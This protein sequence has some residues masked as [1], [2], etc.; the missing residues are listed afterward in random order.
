MDIKEPHK[1]KKKVSSGNRKPSDINRKDTKK[2][3]CTSKKDAKKTEVNQWKKKGDH[4]VQVLSS[5]GINSPLKHKQSAQETNRSGSSRRLRK[6]TRSSAEGASKCDKGSGSY[7][8]KLV[9]RLLPPNL[10]SEMFFKSLQANL[11]SDTFLDEF[12]TDQY[13]VQGHYSKKPF[14]LPKYSRCYF[15]LP[16]MNNLQVLAN[17]LKDMAFVDDHDNSLAP[18]LALSPYVKKMGSEDLKKHVKQQ[19]K[20][21][22]TLVNDVLFQNFMKSVALIAESGGEY[23][24]QDLRILNPIDDELKRRLKRSEIIQ[25][26]AEKAINDLAGID[27]PATTKEEKSKKGSK[28]AGKSAST[29]KGNNQ[30]QAVNQEGGKKKS[31]SKEAKKVAKKKKADKKKKPFKFDMKSDSNSAPVSTPASPPNGNV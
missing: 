4:K 21:E 11:P 16:D 13:F 5:S 24:Y 2:S 14:K 26:Q 12:T 1:S 17:I 23:Q 9:V 27:D 20:H 22:G 19:R 7:G 3:D 28:A 10:T 8:Y 30:C 25:K 18:K 31:E 6:K 29:T 15:T